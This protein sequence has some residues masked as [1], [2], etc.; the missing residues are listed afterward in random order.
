MN[1]EE[2][3]FIDRLYKDLYLDEQVLHHSSGN[4]YD[5]FNNIKEYMEKLESIHTKIGE[6][7]DHKE[8]LRKMYHD[9]YVIKKEDIPESY[10]KH[11]QE[12]ALERGYG[13][14]EITEGD[15]KQYQ[16]QIINDQKASLDVWLSYFISEDAKVYPFWAKY[17]AFQGMLKLGNFNKE[18][19]EFG[20]RT[21]D[22]VAPF[23]DLNREALAISIDMVIKMLNK[24]E[25]EDKE[26]ENLVKSGSFG[27]IYTFVINKVLKDNKNITKRNIG[28]W[29]K[30][31][32]GTDHMILVNSLKGYNTGWCTAGES[33][34]KT[35]LSK[36][37]FYVYYTL[38]ENDEYKVPRIAIR[39]EYGKIAEIR[40]IAKDQNLEPEMEEVVE[41]KIRDF[42]DK[43][44][45]Y[46]KVSDMKLLTQIYKKHKNKEELTKEELA[47]L[48]EI[49]DKIVGFGYKKDPR[50]DEII[51]E[52]KIKKDISFVLDCKEEQVALKES[53]LNK[54][55]IYFKG[56]LKLRGLTSAEGLV[57]PKNIG[58]DL[59]LSGLKSAE[60]LVLP[61]SIGRDL[62]LSGLTSAE[63]LELPK[64]I[65]RGLDLRGLTSAEGL[66]F[67]KNIGG[68]LILYGLTSSKGLVLP[69]S[70]GEHLNLEGLTSAEGLVLPQRIGVSL[71]LSGL[72]SAEGLVIP[73]N[74]TAS[75]YLGGLTSA[76]GLVLP[77]RI[78]RDLILSGLTSAEGLVLPERIGGCL[79]LNGLTS[80]EGLVLPQ[81]IVGYLW[82]DNIT[83]AEGLV[84]PEPLTYTIKMR[85]YE[86]TPENVHEY[87][88]N[89][90]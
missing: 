69:E 75:L 38:D 51:N 30:Y 59:N 15:K 37:D 20:R 85:N 49:D 19:G 87:R 17:W 26:L 41:E 57:L 77:Q 24:E 13:H 55:T 32:Q 62:I 35:Q 34:A 22:T 54:E 31:E 1:K 90:K 56:H 43:E 65:G 40:G 64:T 11:Q 45:Y 2:I 83:S 72:T 14:I 3:R 60:G 88:N 12:I 29:V 9:K 48:Y 21:K 42:P 89:I 73:E 7:G 44:E 47:F 79:Y 25:I 76:E 84:I 74:M 28:R 63:G 82:L 86:I 53:E 27:K 67:P 33:T 70:I 8:L 71:D 23:I 78:G 5:K 66:M 68:S 50:I 10:Y 46:K 52:R 36:G 4:K 16:E 61:E 80:A 39:M 18:K 58:G 81:N 6:T